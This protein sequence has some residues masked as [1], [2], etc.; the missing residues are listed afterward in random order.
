MTKTD[1]NPGLKSRKT[2]FIH[3]GTHKTGTTSIQVE[4]TARREELRSKGVLYP[5]TGCP[6]VARF[7]HH[8][9]PWSLI[10]RSNMM[11]VFKGKTASFSTRQKTRVWKD[12]LIEIK[13]SDCETV[14]LS[15]EEFDVLTP[16]EI[17]AALRFLC[18]F[19]VVPVLFVRNTADLMESSFKTSITYSQDTRSIDVF[20]N[21]QRIRLDYA[22]VISN[23]TGGDPDR[24]SLVLNFDD[25]VI[26]KDVV[27][28]FV[29]HALDGVDFIS[30]AR[31]ENESLPG[32]IIEIV[33]FMR[34]KGLNEERIQSWIA[35]MRRMSAGVK[36]LQTSLIG[37]ELRTELDRAYR[38][39][40]YGLVTSGHLPEFDIDPALKRNAGHFVVHTI[41]DALLCLPETAVKAPSPGS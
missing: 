6:E 32:H 16:G 33:R 14:V 12:L 29:S 30:R 17:D 25:P 41:V 26:R 27:Q 15:S 23:W 35:G 9:L 38:A 31:M 18:D 28:A 34:G 22:E 21:N 13:D 39:E 4:F 2:V 24:A 5:V 3:I 40:F 7:G 8:V 11:P 1:R 19:T 36:P 37:P 20:C 10:E